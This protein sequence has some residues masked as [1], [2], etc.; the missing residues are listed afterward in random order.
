MFD[1]DLLKP[2]GGDASVFLVAW[3]WLKE[4]SY[5]ATHVVV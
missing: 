2:P 1:I 3:Y 4:A 5:V